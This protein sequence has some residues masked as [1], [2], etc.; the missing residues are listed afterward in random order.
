M[1]WQAIT[2]LISRALLHL[3]S[4]RQCRQKKQTLSRSDIGL[5]WSNLPRALFL[6]VNDSLCEMRKVI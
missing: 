6:V 2:L 1:V 3:L 5:K 4:V